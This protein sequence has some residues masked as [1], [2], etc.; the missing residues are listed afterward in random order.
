MEIYPLFKLIGRYLMKSNSDI[1]TPIA[2]HILR[3][4]AAT[5]LKL[6][7]HPCS[8]FDFTATSREDQTFDSD[9]TRLDMKLSERFKRHQMTPF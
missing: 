2:G 9:I 8:T 5:D 7:V 3:R 1:S 6:N 4:V